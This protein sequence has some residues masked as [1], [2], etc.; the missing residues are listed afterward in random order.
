MD[1]R[2]IG[3]EREPLIPFDLRQ[4]RGPMLPEAVAQVLDVLRHGASSV[5]DVETA[6]IGR[7]ELSRRFM[8]LVNSP[9]LGLRGITTVR[10]AVMVVGLAGTRSLLLACG[11]FDC[12]V[13]DHE[14]YGHDA[15]GLFRH[16]AAVGA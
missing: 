13:G 16:S 5:G 12:L 3:A 1:D 2:H 6:L 14:C 9:I 7:P 4:W 8:F 11:A 10:H 15:G